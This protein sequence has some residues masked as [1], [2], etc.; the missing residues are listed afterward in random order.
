MQTIK[1][2]ATQQSVAN[3]GY[4]SIHALCI[5][6]DFAREYMRAQIIGAAIVAAVAVAVRGCA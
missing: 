5:L 6:A 3:S 2:N 4:S 1:K